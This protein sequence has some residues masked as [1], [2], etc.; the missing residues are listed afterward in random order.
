MK[1]TNFFLIIFIFISCSNVNS[2]KNSNYL[3]EGTWSLQF[4]RNLNIDLPAN[5]MFDY[6]KIIQ[7]KT[8]LCLDKNKI[9]YYNIENGEI[10]KTDSLKFPQN[11]SPQAIRCLDPNTIIISATMPHR[12]LIYHI[13]E[14]KQRIFD[15][16]RDEKMAKL[17]P[18]LSLDR[19]G[20]FLLRNNLLYMS[21]ICAGEGIF[22]K[23]DRPNGICLN[24]STGKYSYF[25]DFPDIYY[26]HNWGGLYYRMAFMTGDDLG[27][28]IYSF[29]A[30]NDLYIYNPQNKTTMSV[31]GGS[32]FFSKI[33]PFSNDQNVSVVKV[34][35]DATKHYFI[36]PSYSAVVYD[37]YR[38]LYYRM[39]DFPNPDYGNNDSYYKPCSI[40]IFD[41][42]FKYLGETKLPNL[43]YNQQL[44]VTE[45]GLVVPFFNFQTLRFGFSLF[46]IS[47]K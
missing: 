35:E 5:F 30:C 10:Y 25:M 45:D 3:K 23:G 28:I 17:P 21:G 20:S 7:T 12:I 16:P 47:R 42:S 32:K 19:S 13:K 6:C 2:N 36:N 34:K 29:P 46:T 26:K 33:S 8:L 11:F 4:S 37:N 38:K 24:F 15:L 18:G 44:I 40:I 41:K 22:N 43:V 31:A 27:R 9:Y 39:A 1:M 14:K